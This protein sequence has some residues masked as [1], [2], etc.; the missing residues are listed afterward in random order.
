LWCDE[1]LNK[2]GRFD[3]HIAIYNNLNDKHKGIGE[4]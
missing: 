4:T 2:N 3:A 1:H